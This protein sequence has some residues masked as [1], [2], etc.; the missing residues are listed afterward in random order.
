MTVLEGGPL[1]L[2]RL[3]RTVPFCSGKLGE[4]TVGSSPEPWRIN[5]WA[6][7]GDKKEASGACLIHESILSGPWGAF[8]TAVLLLAGWRVAAGEISPVC[9]REVGVR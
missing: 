2:Y 6:D 9:H 7:L 5:A 4:V 8:S 3:L 1:S